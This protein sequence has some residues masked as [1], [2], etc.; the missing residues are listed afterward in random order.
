LAALRAMRPLQVCVDCTD[1]V[2]WR[3]CWVPADDADNIWDPHRR[4]PC[5]R[6]V[7]CIVARWTPMA[8]QALFAAI[9]ARV[10]LPPGNTDC[11]IPRFG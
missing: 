10:A 6:C 5:G 8:C 7:Q 2:G 3:T 9:D 4:L 1:C 11:R